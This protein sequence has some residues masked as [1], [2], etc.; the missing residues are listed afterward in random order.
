MHYRYYVDKSLIAQGIVTSNRHSRDPLRSMYNLNSI[1][2]GE[3]SP[4][5]RCTAIDI[6]LCEDAAL[7]D[8][9]R[10]FKI[11]Q[12][13]CIDIYSCISRGTSLR[14][15]LYVTRSSGHTRSL[16]VALLAGRRSPCK[17][18]AYARRSVRDRSTKGIGCGIAP[19]G[20]T[21]IAVPVRPFVS[22]LMI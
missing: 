18:L 20:S 3:L 6:A 1:L 11:H 14:A 5:E 2:K 4:F 19:W 9:H 13:R 21:K 15:R 10:D 17:L 12:T 16:A 22:P 8:E 7:A